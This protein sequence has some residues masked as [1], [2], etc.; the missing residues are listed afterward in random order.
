MLL[1]NLTPDDVSAEIGRVKLFIV[2]QNHHIRGRKLSVRGEHHHH[3]DPLLVQRLIFQADIQVHGL[4]KGKSIGL[5]ESVIS[6]FPL[7]EIIL[8]SENQLV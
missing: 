2:L 7:E 3:V 4:L 1:Q 8:C 5:A 6:V